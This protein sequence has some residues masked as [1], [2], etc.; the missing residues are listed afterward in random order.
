MLQ[1]MHW[2]YKAFDHFQPFLYI[3]EFKDTYIFLK[4]RLKSFCEFIHVFSF[5]L[6]PLQCLQW[7]DITFLHPQQCMFYVISFFLEDFK[8][9]LSTK[10]KIARKK[11]QEEKE[12]DS[13]I[14]FQKFWIF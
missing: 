2:R 14:M 10:R 13:D 8:C 9:F 5:F 3:S 11:M 1:T 4:S 12:K 7:K 6:F